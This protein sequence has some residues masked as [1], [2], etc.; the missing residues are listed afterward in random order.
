VDDE[1][2]QRQVACPYCRRTI[3]APATSTIE[4]LTPPTAKPLGRIG[5][6]ERTAEAAFGAAPPSGP[7]GT[8]IAEGNPYAVWALGTSIFAV[9]CLFG[10]SAMILSQISGT[11]APDSTSEEIQESFAELQKQWVSE[12]QKGK[13]PPVVAVLGL[14]TCATVMTWTAGLVLTVLALRR[15][16]RRQM[17][18]AALVITLLLPLYLFISTIARF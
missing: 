13:M 4:P 17:S 10:I 11:V 15:R 5:L 16:A 6:D 18:I 8:A 2:A 7:P 12:A 14:G 1:W 9:L 3:T